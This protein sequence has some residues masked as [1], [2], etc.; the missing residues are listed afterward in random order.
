MARG[1]TMRIIARFMRTVNPSH[2]CTGTWDFVGRGLVGPGSAAVYNAAARPPKEGRNLD[3]KH[4][5][6][7]PI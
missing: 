2:N 3:G 7:D 1:K 6:F 5:H 4:P